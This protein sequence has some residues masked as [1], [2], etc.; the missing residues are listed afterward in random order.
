MK[1]KFLLLVYLIS[2]LNHVFAQLKGSS[3]QFPERFSPN[4]FFDPGQ[5]YLKIKDIQ[6]AGF[7]A[8]QMDYY[9]ITK[10]YDVQRDFDNNSYYLEWYDL[11]KYL[12]KLIDTI[13]PLNIKAKQPYDVFIE[14]DIDYNA[15]ALGNGFVFVNIGLLANCNN[16]SELAYVLGHEIGHSIFN[17][18]YMINSSFVSAYNR[19]DYSGISNQYDLMFQKSRNAELQSDSFA[20]RCLNKAHLN[21]KTIVNSL[22]TIQYAE[23]ASTFYVSKTRRSSYANYM[24][25]YGTHPNS[26][27]RKKLLHKF[28]KE[29][30][31]ELSKFVIDSAYFYKIRKIAH[32]EC[33]KLSMES[34]DYENSL[35]LSFIDYLLGDNSFKNLFYI[36]ESTRRLLYTQP[37]LYKSGFLAE[38]LK[39]S[40]FENTNSSILKMPD[41]LFIDSVQ[42][43]KA[44]SHPLIAEEEKPFNTYEEAYLYFTNLAEEKGFNESVFSKA[45][46]YYSKK[47]DVNFKD[48]LNKYIEKG[49]GLFM[50]LANNLN[51]YGYPYIKEGKT[52]VL[53]DNSTNFSHNDNYFHS[54]QRISSNNDIYAAFKNDSAKIKLTLMNEILGIMPNKLFNYQKIKWHLNQLYT[55]ND[56]EYF[57]KKRY[58]SKEDMEERTKRNKY[59]KNLLIF[60]PE[61]YKW[62]VDNNFNGI[63]YQ[64]VKYEYPSVKA[65]EEYHNFYSLGYFNFFDNRPFF[66]KCIRNGSVRKQKPSLM[67]NEAREY[68]FYKE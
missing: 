18:G 59:N 6:V 52:N 27:D 20:Y 7:T 60:A 2:Q 44:S 8:D 38:D 28:Q 19:K 58:Q 53:I 33:K 47:D 56:E 1:F 39:Y 48:K 34:G 10:T 35:K 25:T 66:G 16:E 23:Y 26:L 46:Y 3:Y 12:Y 57:Y 42:F 36:F 54:L 45:L 61:M 15:H 21:T 64:K 29:H 13:L 32:E 11:E 41:L 30:K 24:K 5:S 9:K 65:P 67:A 17:H 22:N 63:L 62:F 55:E 31:A 40:E 50:D 14:R 4:Y 43:V 51:K 37:D 49:S 68:L